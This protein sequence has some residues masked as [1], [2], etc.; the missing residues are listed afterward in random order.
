MYSLKYSTANEILVEYQ[1]QFARVINP[2][3]EVGGVQQDID[4]LMFTRGTFDHRALSKNLKVAEISGIGFTVPW[5][6]GSEKCHFLA[7][8]TLECRSL[9]GSKGKLASSFLSDNSYCLVHPSCSLPRS[10]RH[11][12]M[13]EAR[14]YSSLRRSP[15]QL[16]LQPRS[17][18]PDQRRRLRYDTSNAGFEANSASAKSKILTVLTSMGSLW[19][20]Q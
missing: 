14:C 15:R 20:C 9:N 11:Y 2:F 17:C 10:S 19:D 4:A 7:S 1:N 5:F 16:N 18:L 8:E 3:R 13:L 12:S 6:H